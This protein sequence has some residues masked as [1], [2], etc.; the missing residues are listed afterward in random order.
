M[1]G[2]LE[3]QYSLDSP[4]T[5]GSFSGVAPEMHAALDP[6]VKL[7]ISREDNRLDTWIAGKLIYE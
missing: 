6:N 5:R 4:S 7:P 3:T 2:I 1:Q